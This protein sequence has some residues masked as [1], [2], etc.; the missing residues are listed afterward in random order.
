MKKANLILTLSFILFNL[1]TNAQTT[2]LKGKI[3]I[4]DPRY[5]KGVDSEFLLAPEAIIYSAD[6]IKLG[7][8]NKRGIFEIEVPS[9]TSKIIVSWV[10]YDLEPIE[11]SGTCD[12]IE[13]VLIPA[14]IYDFVSLKRANKLNQRH[15]KKWLPEL[16]QQASEQG[17]ITSENPC[18]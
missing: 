12:F 8:T 16:Y 18:R 7:T 11:L 14:V 15:R 6:T 3:I 17:F 4:S 10:G 5:V 1:T 13:V 9:S 2:T